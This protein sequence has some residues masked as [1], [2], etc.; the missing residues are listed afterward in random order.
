MD[1]DDP[2]YFGNSR[3]WIVQE[4]ENSLRR[5]RTD[6]IDLY[7]IHRPELDT[8][9]DDTLVGAQRPGPRRARSATS[10]RSTF[11]PSAVVE[12][13][14]VAEKRNRQRFVTEQPPYSILVRAIERDLLPTCERFGMGVLPWSPL[15]GGWLTGRY[16]KGAEVP[17]SRRAAMVPDRYDMS[18]PENQAKLEAVDALAELAEEAG[19]TMIE[20]SLAFCLEHPAVTAPIIGPRT[21]EQLESQLPA[22][23]VRL[24]QD[25]LDRID[26]IVPP[27][28]TVNPV[29]DGWTPPAIADP[30]LRRRS[31]QGL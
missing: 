8:D 22:A 5:L 24:S 15:A 6:H 18:K 10:A 9:I 12:A 11:P 14:W 21:M 20:M 2:N 27:G 31:L 19:L 4:V 13:Q 26:E 28:R 1:D 25:V 16:R 23:D 17:K 29:D 30:R 3:R 7:Q